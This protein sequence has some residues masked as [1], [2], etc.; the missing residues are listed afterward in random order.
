M[1]RQCNITPFLASTSFLDLSIYNIYIYIIYILVSPNVHVFFLTLE[2]I[3]RT[4]H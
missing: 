3:M 4:R 1:S 2:M